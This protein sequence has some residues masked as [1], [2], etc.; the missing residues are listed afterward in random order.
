MPV[1]HLLFPQMPHSIM[2]PRLHPHCALVWSISCSPAFTCLNSCSFF[3]KPF[4]PLAFS[5][6]EMTFL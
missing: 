2:L 6:V 1:N 5:S 3:K 4:Y